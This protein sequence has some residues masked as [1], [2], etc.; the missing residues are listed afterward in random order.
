MYKFFVLL[1]AM[2]VALST[3]VITVSAEE[4]FVASAGDSISSTLE[5]SEANGIITRDFVFECDLLFN[6]QRGQYGITFRYNDSAKNSKGEFNETGSRLYA[7]VSP[8][9]GGQVAIVGYGDRTT[10]NDNYYFKNDGRDNFKTGQTY[11]LKVIAIGG[12]ITLWIDDELLL[13][14]ADPLSDSFEGGVALFY[15]GNKATFSN[16]KIIYGQLS[17]STI[18]KAMPA[19]K[20]DKLLFEDKFDNGITNWNVFRTADWSVEKDTDGDNVLMSTKS[21]GAYAVIKNHQWSD[22]VLEC[23]FA[24]Y[25]D[26]GTP[27]GQWGITFRYDEDTAYSGT[28]GRFNETSNRM[29]LLITP[30]R[31]GNI[32]FVGYGNKA[33][34]SSSNPTYSL[35]ANNRSNFVPGKKYHLKLSVVGQIMKV[36]LD[37]ELIL[38]A[39]DPDMTAVASKIGFVSSY[40]PISIDNLKIESVDSM[41]FSE[42]TNQNIKLTINNVERQ[43]DQPPIKIFDQVYVPIRDVFETFGAN[44]TWNN[45]T[46]TISTKRLQTETSIKIDDDK[47]VINGETVDIGAPVKLV[48][49]TAVAPLKYVNEVLGASVVW[50]SE[51]NIV[52]IAHNVVP[53]DVDLSSLVK[54]HPRIWMNQADIDKLKERVLNSSDDSLYKRVYNASIEQINTYLETEM[55][56]GNDYTKTTLSEQQIASSRLEYLSMAY[57]LTGD[58][59]YYD[60]A[61]EWLDYLLGLNHWS[62]SYN[63]GTAAIMEGV[64]TAYDWLYDDIS[65]ELKATIRK[66]MIEKG[67]NLGLAAHRYNKWWITANNNNW[68]HSCA[69]GMIL[70]ALAIAD[71]DPELCEEL[72]GKAIGSLSIGMSG[73]SPDGGWGEGFSYWMSSS[74]GPTVTALTALNSALGTDY[75]LSDLKGFSETGYFPMYGTGPTGYPMGYADTHSTR[76]RWLAPG[77]LWL[78]GRY[79][80]PDIAADH[81]RAMESLNS[82]N[83]IFNLY[84]WYD[85][86]EGTNPLENTPL[87]K[88][89]R[90][91]TEVAT[92]RSSWD[93]PNALFLG[94][95]AGYTLESHAHLDLGT[96][97]IDALGVKW[98]KDL[99]YGNATMPGYYDSAEDSL[100]L[101]YYN[102]SSISHNVPLI[103][104][105]N[106][107]YN[108]KADVMDYVSNPDYGF[109][110]IDLSDSYRD[111]ERVV[112]GAQMLPGRKSILIQD[113]IT[114]L[115]KHNLAWGLTTDSVVTVDGNHAV[116]EKDGKKMHVELICSV[117]NARFSIESAERELP[118]PENK[119]FSRLMVRLPDQIGEVTIAVVFTPEGNEYI[120]P[121]IVPVD[122]WK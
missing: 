116:L 90:G 63:L 121:E 96:F 53:V 11:R 10:L 41:T 110:T 122:D 54:T 25:F 42:D 65:D 44:V 28:D 71:T 87:D 119:G 9:Y 6:E 1:L 68:N 3:V 101:T 91:T 35:K 7:M 46:N 45:Y 60:R 30:K 37:D 64:A 109:M 88:M 75:G 80:K 102:I 43:F 89:F 34:V 73:F 21:G 32:S 117:D 78:A 26:T 24:G 92:F 74:F 39:F 14:S 94:I 16:V 69:R 31:D 13:S 20:K 22:F 27:D 29:L 79:D 86:P 36:W 2:I 105:K 85:I 38:K 72:L 93:D 52:R 12:T 77:S 98:A 83:N 55:L 81:Y 100:R 17:E 5:F 104:D 107:S 70:G 76:Q 97:E 33:S 57:K 95:K 62:T 120:Q 56:T 113:E 8:M 59:K 118:E 114:L 15:N 67:I 82:F 58:K 61:M 19:L 47:V 49:D 108:S 4:T 115:S 18:K 84:W 50:D 23:D 103:D 51:E 106:Q 111:A 112:R 48:N 99:G 40:N 66:N